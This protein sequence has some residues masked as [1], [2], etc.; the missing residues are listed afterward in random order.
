MHHSGAQVRRNTTFKYQQRKNDKQNIQEVL[1]I[2]KKANQNNSQN[3][4]ENNTKAS[5][6]RDYPM[7]LQ[8]RQIT[9]LVL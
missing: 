4:G 3:T 9:N 2:I 5:V 1:V 6:Y 8:Q 7:K